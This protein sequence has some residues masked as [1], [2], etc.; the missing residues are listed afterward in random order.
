MKINSNSL[1]RSIVKTSNPKGKC[2]DNNYG[3]TLI[4]L[5][6]AIS[7]FSVV[8]TAVY[9]SYRATFRN[10]DGMEKY[11][12]NT[13]TARVLFERISADLNGMFIDERGLFKKVNSGEFTEQRLTFASTANLSFT[14]N[15]KSSGLTMIH[16]YLKSDEETGFATIYRSDVPFAPKQDGESDTLLD[17]GI[18]IAEGVKDFQLVLLGDG[19]QEA[20]EWDSKQ[21]SEMN[22]RDEADEPLFPKLLKI[23]LVMVHPRDENSEQKF[24]SAVAIPQ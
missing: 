19:N 20:G 13:M 16:Y 18:M 12:K 24:M 9:S 5:L 1:T 23:S 22:E 14:R 17:E 6:V 11:A 7:I 3:F 21:L 4:E 8:V 15:G 10:I 2:D